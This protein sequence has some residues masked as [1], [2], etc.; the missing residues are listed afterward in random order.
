V[1]VKQKGIDAHATIVTV[2]KVLTT[3]DSTE[4]TSTAMIGRFIVAHPQVT[5]VTMISTKPC[6]TRN[7]IVAN[8]NTKVKKRAREESS[9]ERQLSG[10]DKNDATTGQNLAQKK[11][12]MEPKR[13]EIPLQTRQT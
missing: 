5:N 7:A 13:K 10:W 1:I 2:T 6:T 9:Q 11:K 12:K 4:S 3:T 8:K